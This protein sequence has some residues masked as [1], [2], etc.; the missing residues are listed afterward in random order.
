V[1]ATALGTVTVAVLGAFLLA[2]ALA[3]MFDRPS[4]VV[5]VIAGVLASPVPYYVLYEPTMAHGVVFG[6]AG[7]FLWAW[8]EADR[9][10]SA[11]HWARLGALL[12][13]LALTRWQAIV[14]AALLLPLALAGLRRHRVRPQWIAVAALCAFAVFVPQLVAWKVIYGRFLALPTREN[15]VDWSSPHLLQVLLS[16]DRGLFAREISPSQQASRRE[17]AVLLADVLSRL[18]DDYGVD[19]QKIPNEIGGQLAYPFRR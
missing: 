16:A 12:G 18:P 3:S 13:L 17:Q 5:G 10:P 8:T 4:V 14:Y 15:A 2:R 7:M 9:Q 6:L 1:R 19:D 11:R